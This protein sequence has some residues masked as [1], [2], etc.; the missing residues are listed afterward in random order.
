MEVG[1]PPCPIGK[2]PTAGGI[3]GKAFG[4][5]LDVACAAATSSGLNEKAE[6]VGS[7]VC[8]GCEVGIKAGCVFGEIGCL[9]GSVAV[10]LLG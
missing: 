2:F 3:F 4:G 8:G 1:S 6:L 10:E 5:N 7:V 9:F